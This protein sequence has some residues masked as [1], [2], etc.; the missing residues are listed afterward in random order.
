MQ[1]YIFLIFVILLIISFSLYKL[2]CT[3]K[4]L[5]EVIQEQWIRN[6]GK[7]PALF[8]VDLI[9]ESGKIQFG[10]KP[11]EVSW[12]LSNKTKSKILMYRVSK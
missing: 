6:K 11:S 1:G 12:D 7:K 10:V 3:R 5:L 4:I 2:F 8:N 9:F